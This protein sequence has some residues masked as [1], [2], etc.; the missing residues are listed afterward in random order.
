MKLNELN[1]ITEPNRST[2]IMPVLFLGHGE[3]Q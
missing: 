2:D 1:N 3:P